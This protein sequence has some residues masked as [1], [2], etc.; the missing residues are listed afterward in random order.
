MLRTWIRLFTLAAISFALAVPADAQVK[1]APRSEDLVLRGKIVKVE[2]PDR[3]VVRT[4]A[5]KEVTV[6]TSPQ[7]RYVI[8]GKAAR[9]SD[10]RVGAVINAPYVVRDDRHIVNS[11]TV[12]VAAADPLSPRAAEGTVVRG[13][14]VSVD[15][16]AK[17]IIKT[18]S[19]DEMILVSNP[20]TRI[21]INGKVGKLTELRAGTEVNANYLVREGR[22][23]VS[24]ITVGASPVQGEIQQVGG[25]VRRS[26]TLRGKIVGVES[27][28]HVTIRTAEG[29]EVT[30][31]AGPKTRYL[32]NGKTGRFA[33]L[34]VGVEVNTDYIER[35]NKM[36]VETIT[37]G[38]AAE[39]DPAP[40]AEG[41]LVQGT[42][43]RVVGEDQVVVKT[44]QNK[45]VV[46]YV[47]PQTKYTFE[48]R[49]GRFTDIRSGSD[50]RIQYDVRDRRNVAR[51]IIGLRRNKN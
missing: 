20:Q 31:I 36:I 40:A 27:P 41:T 18:A 32:V 33:D 34:R 50:V 30:F 10:L 51:S 17:I 22:K 9:Y 13:K 47:V 5:D 35:D 28:N 49:P 39:T 14:I 21:V 44:P 8:D 38:P 25:E 4:S 11:V 42:V 7:T 3:F 46:V 16:P 15:D 43:V 45:E 24:T 48:E 12:G 6:Y 26:T 19:G 1:D 23:M 29:R 37:I 2:A